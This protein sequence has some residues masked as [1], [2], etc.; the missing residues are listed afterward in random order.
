[1]R[2]FLKIFLAALICFSAAALAAT[3]PSADFNTLVDKYFDF[4]FQ[5][6]PSEATQDGL[7]EYDSKLEDFSAAGRARETAGLTDYL[8][9]FGKVDRSQLPPDTAADL[10]WMISSIHSQLLELENIQM[11]KKDPDSYTSDVTDSVFSLMKRNFAP[12][13]QRLQ[14]VIDRERQFP[15][16]FEAAR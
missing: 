14:A 1:M 13:E 10:D 3:D 7:H 16:A 2:T 4:Y 9:Q 11:W 5:W 12:P 15:K 6:N 8:N